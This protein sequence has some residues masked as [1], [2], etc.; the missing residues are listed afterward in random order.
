MSALQVPPRAGFLNIVL[1]RHH[2][3]AYTLVAQVLASIRNVSSLI[4]PLSPEPSIMHWHTHE[5]HMYSVSH[6]YQ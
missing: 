4:L 5:N 2:L 3:R 6:C 1:L